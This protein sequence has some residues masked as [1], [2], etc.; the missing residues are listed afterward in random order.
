MRRGRVAESA[1]YRSESSRQRAEGFFLNDADSE[2]T[3]LHLT[4]FK[5]FTHFLTRMA[6]VD[7]LGREQKGRHG[8]LSQGEHTR[9][10]CQAAANN[11][12]C[13]SMNG[14]HRS[15]VAVYVG[16]TGERAWG[17]STRAIPLALARVG[18]AVRR[19]DN[20]I[21]RQTGRQS[22]TSDRQIDRQFN[23]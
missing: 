16:C 6:F 23:P 4:L 2:R 11:A 18:A 12:K 9:V 19:T 3:T 14:S 7:R 15:F 8:C 1:S 10:V 20:E 5:S 13:Q 21:D 17:R 22:Q